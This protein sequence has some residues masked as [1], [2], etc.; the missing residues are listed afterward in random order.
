M[1]L[2]YQ[3]DCSSLIAGISGASAVLALQTEMHNFSADKATAAPTTTG[4][5]QDLV[6]QQA[7]ETEAPA[8]ASLQPKSQQQRLP[9]SAG[10][11][12]TLSCC[13][14]QQLTALDWAAPER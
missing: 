10:T 8:A 12:S 6:V 9:P 1:A 3:L 4:A 7:A 2:A 11:Y 5:Q 13:S 14:T